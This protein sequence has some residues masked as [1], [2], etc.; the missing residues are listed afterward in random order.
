[1]SYRTARA[2]AAV[3]GYVKYLLLII[4]SI[5]VIFLDTIEYF[6]GTFAFF[7]QYF[8]CYMYRN[9]VYPIV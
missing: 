3:A 7:L 6:V 2:T 5:E 8:P 4:K 9:R 1:M